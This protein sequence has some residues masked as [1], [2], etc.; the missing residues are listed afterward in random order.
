MVGFVEYPD[1]VRAQCRS[2]TTETWL[3]VARA[4]GSALPDL[5]SA[6]QISPA[7]GL[8]RVD[9]TI[10]LGDLIDLAA[11]QAAALHPVPAASAS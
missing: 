4:D 1:S 10:A 11:R 8:H 9:V 6:G 7:W 5:A 2:T 3:E